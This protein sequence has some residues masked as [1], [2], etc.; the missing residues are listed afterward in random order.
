[1]PN[2]AECY[3]A[4]IR[5][6]TSRDDAPQRIHEL[7]LSEM[8]RIRAEMETLSAVLFPGKKLEDVLTMLRDDMK[9][10][11]TTRDEVE[12]AAVTAVERA[13]AR[14][15]EV[16]SVLPKAPVVV[17]RL[18]A[19]AEKDS[20]MAYYRHASL[21]GKRPGAYLV[22]TYMPEERPRYTAEVLAFHEAVPGHHLQ[23]SIAQELEGLPDFQK[24][25][26]T[27]AFVEGWALYTERLCD[28][29]G[30]YSGDLD[31][32]GMLSFDAWRAARLVVDTGMHSLG[33]TRQQA[34]DYMVANTASTVPDITNEIDRYITW[35]GQALAYKIGQV[36]ILRLRERAKR[37][38]GDA[39]DLREFHRRVLRNGAVPLGVLAEEIERWIAGV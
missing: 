2:G 32:L 4:R 5:R 27:T 11:F 12:R 15:P 1:M 7:G 26:G 36:E 10:G 38:L 8:A 29:M 19:H 18:E 28:E 16:F 31:R 14:L 23:V 22:N 24:N 20:P 39:F 9:Y 13:R 35:G 3:R 37:E 17:E 34:I 21:D 33:W 6:H 30:L 25:A